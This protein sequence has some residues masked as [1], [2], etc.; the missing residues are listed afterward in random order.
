MGLLE[1]IIAAVIA[2]IFSGILTG[3]GLAIGTYLANKSVIK[4]L[5]K[6]ESKLNQKP[7]LKT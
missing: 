7:E 2:G 3:A 6:I 4:H 1:T 5:D